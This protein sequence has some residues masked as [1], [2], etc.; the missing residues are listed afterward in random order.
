MVNRPICSASD[1]DQGTLSGWISFSLR[2]GFLYQKPYGAV[3][4]GGGERMCLCYFCFVLHLCQCLKRVVLNLC[5]VFVFLSW[6]LTR[7]A[8]LCFTPP[9]DGERPDP[10]VVI[11][12]FIHPWYR[13]RARACVSLYHSSWSR[14]DVCVVILCFTPPEC[15]KRVHACVKSVFHPDYWLWGEGWRLAVSAVSHTWCWLLMAHLRGD[16]RSSFMI[17]YL[18]F[19]IIVWFA[20][21]MKW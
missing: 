1:Q 8:F 13:E 9:D 16:W 4:G 17:F 15:R 2:I 5:C 11:L 21:H 10:C 12:C 6:C 14:V 20:H 19:V 7:S 18:W 3:K